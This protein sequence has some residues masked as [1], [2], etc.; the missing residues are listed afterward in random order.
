MPSSLPF[1]T[2]DC[3]PKSQLPGPCW[4]YGNLGNYEAYYSNTPLIFLTSRLSGFASC[5]QIQGSCSYEIFLMEKKY[6]SQLCYHQKYS[7]LIVFLILCRTKLLWWSS[8]R[9]HP[10]QPIMSKG[11]SQRSINVVDSN[12]L[13]GPKTYLNL[14]CKSFFF[15]C[16][17][18]N[19]HG[20][21]SI[22]I[23]TFFVISKCLFYICWK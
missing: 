9:L 6:C 17:W 2:L 10:K 16:N 7:V 13:S 15:F 12:F 23:E 4:M 5:K 19:K 14:I 1:E 11:W 3:A 21:V 20:M 22:E 18:F 8:S